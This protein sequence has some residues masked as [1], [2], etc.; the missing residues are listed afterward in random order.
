MPSNTMLAM[1]LT[2][3]FTI[4]FYHA[5]HAGEETLTGGAKDSGVELTARL[6]HTT[7]NF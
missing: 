6:G 1:L 7:E 2:A 4:R 3:A 5:S